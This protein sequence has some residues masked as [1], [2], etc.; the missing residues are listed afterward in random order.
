MIEPAQAIVMTAM[1]VSL[2]VPKGKGTPRE[3]FGKLGRAVHKKWIG[4]PT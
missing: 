4:R 1:L 2:L 3:F